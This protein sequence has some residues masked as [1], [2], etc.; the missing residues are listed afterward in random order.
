MNTLRKVPFLTS[1][2][3][4]MC[5]PSILVERVKSTSNAFYAKQEFISIVSMTSKWDV[6]ADSMRFLKSLMTSNS[7]ECIM[8]LRTLKIRYFWRI[9]FRMLDFLNLRYQAKALIKAKRRLNRFYA[10]EIIIT[11][12]IKRFLLRSSKY[13]Q[14]L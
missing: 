8:S 3:N 13:L 1:S 2:K 12:L 14:A 7:R 5:V 10:R 6:S 4:V 9:S 11:M